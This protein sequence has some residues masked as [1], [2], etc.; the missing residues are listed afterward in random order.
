MESIERLNRAIHYI[1]GET[2]MKRI[3]NNR[4]LIDG[5]KGHNYGLPDCVKFIL[6]CIGEGEKPDFWDIAAITGDTVAQVYNRN[7]STGCEYCPSGYLAGAE[8]IKYVFDTLGYNHEY[9][10]AKELN[11]D[12]NRYIQKIVEMIDRDIPVLVKTNLH[13]IPDWNSDVGTHCLIVGYNHGGHIVR[14]LFH[15]TDVNQSADANQTSY[16]DCILTGENKMDLIFI[17]EKQR[18][19][20]LEELYIKAIKKIPHWLTLPERDG[21][22]FGAM[23]FRVWADDI[24]AGR[25][26]DENIPLWENYGVYVAHL[27]TNAGGVSTNIFK[28]LAGM[29]P[30]YSYLIPLREKINKILEDG[31][32]SRDGRCGL[33][34]KLDKLGAGMDMDE[35]RITMRDKEKRSKI[36]NLFRD[37]AGRLDQVVEIINDMMSKFN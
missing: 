29:N 28:D 14:L 21:K 22:C 30:S 6:E 11:A 3:K 15:D 12:K 20:T 2:I 16:I 19:V 33:W 37:Y 23:A 27:A 34:V 7:L 32:G 9:V 8:N 13:D 26:D 10:T 36:S 5:G 35:V 31:N 4:P 1:E 17:G 24:D 25:F 18:E